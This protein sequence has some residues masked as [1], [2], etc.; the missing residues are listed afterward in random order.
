MR[1]GVG[2]Y[3]G[4]QRRQAQEIISAHLSGDVGLRDRLVEE[5]CRGCDEM[6]ACFLHFIFVSVATGPRESVKARFAIQQWMLG[7]V[8]EDVARSRGV[9]ALEVAIEL[10]D[11]DLVEAFGGA[12][13]RDPRG[14]MRAAQTA[15]ASHMVSRRTGQP[16]G[17]AT[18]VVDEGDSLAQLTMGAH[19]LLVAVCCQATGRLGNPVVVGLLLPRLQELLELG[20]RGHCQ[21]VDEFTADLWMKHLVRDAQMREG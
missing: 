21:F 15:L 10:M 11:G 17:I 19:F 13:G 20:A 9:G 5:Y 2:L 14:V 3:S 18:A 7:D 6:L 4:Q 12:P 1:G 16:W 8:V